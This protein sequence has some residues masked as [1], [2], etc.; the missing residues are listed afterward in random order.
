MM[1]Q[2]HNQLSN[3]YLKYSF[4]MSVLRMCTSC[5]HHH[6]LQFLLNFYF[7][8]QVKSISIANFSIH[9]TTSQKLHVSHLPHLKQ[10]HTHNTTRAVPILF[11]T[12]LQT[13]FSFVWFLLLKKCRKK[14]CISKY[15][16][17]FCINYDTY[18]KKSISSATF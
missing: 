1:W 13:F 6:M 10:T 12:F 16:L 5:L 14:F 4:M 9:F 17:W 3:D 2:V 15:W 11:D 7:K 18:V 8:K